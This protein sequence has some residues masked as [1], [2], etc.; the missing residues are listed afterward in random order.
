MDT[1]DNLTASS[2]ESSALPR[3]VTKT[4]R[5]TWVNYIDPQRDRKRKQN[6][7]AVRKA[8]KL[9]TLPSP[10]TTTLES[11][12][13]NSAQTTSI[14]TTSSAKE[15]FDTP[16]LITLSTRD[17]SSRSSS[18]MMRS[19]N[20][21]PFDSLPIHTDNRSFS[22]LNRYLQSVHIR[23]ECM[24]SCPKTLEL[25]RQYLLPTLVRSRGTLHVAR[26]SATNRI[27][28]VLRYLQLSQEYKV[29]F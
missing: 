21:D 29:G 24:T 23:P 13:T 28:P 9:S 27:L 12:P 11:I 18:P 10:T 14:T 1:P 15:S 6:R 3:S 7:A 2:E 26:E 16:E 20:S 4:D 5:L 22:F 25:R 17:A 8:A 19:G